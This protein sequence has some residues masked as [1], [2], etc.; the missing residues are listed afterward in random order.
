MAA[1]EFVVIAGDRI[2]GTSRTVTTDFLGH[3]AA[4]PVGPYV[5]ASLF[6]CPLYLLGCI[7][8]GAATPSAECLS[9]RVVLPRGRRVAALTTIINTNRAGDG[10]GE[11][12]A[13][14]LVQ[15]LSLLG[16]G[17]CLR[18]ESRE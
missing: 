2:G 9:R 1:G 16:S 13:V 8:E 10:A 18:Q 11:A 14:R 3:P 6:K 4:F 12:L 5:L 17:E 15:L 7:H